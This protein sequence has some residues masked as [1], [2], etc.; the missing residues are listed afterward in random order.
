VN[1]QNLLQDRILALVNMVMEFGLHNRRG[2]GRTAGR[3][4]T[5]LVDDTNTDMER[6][7]A[8]LRVLDSR[9]FVNTVMSHNVP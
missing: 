2:I 6:N 5:K 9:N 3:L 1:R 7:S 8:R 4:T